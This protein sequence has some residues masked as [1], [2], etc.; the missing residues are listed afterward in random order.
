M[1]KSIITILFV[2][3][4]PSWFFAQNAI[5]TVGVLPSTPEAANFEKY[6]NIPVSY[7]SGVPQ[8]SVPIHT[9]NL[10][11][12]SIPI[13]LSYHS[14]G[15]KVDETASNVGLGWVLN[16]GGLI[17]CNTRGNPDFDTYGYASASN[18]SQ[19]IYDRYIFGA[20]QEETINDDV[21]QDDDH[22]LL[23]NIASGYIDGQPDLFHY[24]YP[25]G[26]GKFVYD[27]TK[28]P[29][30]IPFKAIKIE[31]LNGGGTYEITDE[32]GNI[33]EFSDRE[34][35]LIR[36]AFGS[37]CDVINPLY[38]TAPVTPTWHLS[39]I[40]T[41]YNEVV[42]FNYDTVSY[43]YEYI[44]SQQ[45]FV[46]EN[47]ANGNP[48]E[49]CSQRP[50]VECKNIIDVIVGK[51]LSSIISSDGTEINFLYGNQ[52][53][54]DL[55][56]TNRIGQI[57]L[58]YNSQELDSWAFDH[59][60]FT[61]NCTNEACYRLKLDK[62]TRNGYPSYE[63]F[64]DESIPVSKRNS[65]GQDHWGYYNGKDNNSTFL[66]AT[67]YKAIVLPGADRTPDFQ[68]TKAG[69]LNK[70][71]YPTGGETVFEYEP[72]EYWFDGTE[73]TY[74][75][76][77]SQVLSVNGVATGSPISTQFTV[78]GSEDVFG[79]FKFACTGGDYC[80]NP[81]NVP[82]GDL[83]VARV[84]GNGIDIAYDYPYNPSPYGTDTPIELSPGTYTMTLF[85]SVDG[86]YGTFKVEWVEVGEA[87]VQENRIG[88][89]LRIKRMTDKP[90]IGKDIIKEFAYHLPND[91]SKSSGFTS[92]E[93]SYTSWVTD[94]WFET[95]TQS[96]FAEYVCL[97]FSRSSHNL[98]NVSSI[99][100]GYVGYE[101]VTILDGLNGKNG[102]TVN[103]YTTYEDSGDN[104]LL[105]PFVPPTSY[106]WIRGL[107]KEQS[108][109][110]KEGSSFEKTREITFDYDIRHGFNGVFENHP[111]ENN[112]LGLKITTLRPFYS[113]GLVSK[114]SRLDIG[115]YWT[116]ASWYSLASKVDKQYSSDGSGTLVT[117][118]KNYY[119]D[120]PLH[121]LLTREEMDSSDGD[122]VVSKTFYPDDITLVSSLGLPNLSPTE[123]AEVDKLKESGSH[124]I[125]EPVQ[126]VS[127]KN[128]DSTVQ[129]INFKD[130]GNSIVKPERTN[131][132]KGT[133]S[134][135][136]EFQNLVKYLDY[137]GLGNPLEVSREN[138]PTTS[139]IW[140]HNK[141]YIIAKVENASYDDIALALGV[142]VATLKTY[143]E[144]N[145]TA[146]NGL[147][148]SLPNS[149][150]TT[151]TY[152]PLVGVTSIT[153]PR[154]YTTIY[155][156]DDFNRLKEV[157]DKDNNL[158]SDTEYHYKN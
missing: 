27:E 126:T 5:S 154:G 41:P 127:I 96:S 74:T 42:T 91:I 64:Y 10:K 11:N 120:N 125:S 37:D 47:D 43:E 33:F 100:G 69:I 153:D 150:I 20:F 102:K 155:V 141:H 124:R 140:G 21:N 94:W 109:Y 19:H 8:I 25:G 111:N 31:R 50:A 107:L 145:L 53:R 144:S 2:V 60:Y 71:I 129:R 67:N 14:S 76:K 142:T 104:V 80:S 59:S 61:A 58:L 133:Y 116:V 137:D 143:D 117:T 15:I 158:L 110:K 139:Y 90:I 52:D 22:D 98:A 46:R 134:S 103:R 7:F 62:L 131:F 63:F 38:P 149:M 93:T 23:D 75:T 1:K 113:I 147:R 118:T 16:A 66:P 9:I 119:Y 51:R 99:N 44:S 45:D 152:E 92:Y 77:S 4:I 12:L 28:T 17:S 85:A 68:Y 55:P 34:T 72:N 83:M 18:P 40:T 146:I 88:G 36:P 121:G 70:I 105:W 136:N 148:Q 122:T 32:K 135:T 106:D 82:P 54:L 157:R 108:V 128:G 35:S 29:K 87:N 56:G 30:T 78:P 39:K 81:S 57:K 79:T 115:A 97:Y 123:K 114:Q 13:N 65:F 130:F 24:S 95:L 156:Y 138:S 112:I 3:A 73:T 49:G 101:Y 151:Y 48:V 132:L 6:G 84:T 26:S 89:G 86:F